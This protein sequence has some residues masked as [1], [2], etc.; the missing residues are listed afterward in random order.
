MPP[1]KYFSTSAPAFK[2]TLSEYIFGK[3]N[4]YRFEHVSI[5]DT[6]RL[7]LGKRKSIFS[8]RT[9]TM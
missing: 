4:L 3:R 7:V 5:Y 8:T 1:T 2:S 6:Q 9:F